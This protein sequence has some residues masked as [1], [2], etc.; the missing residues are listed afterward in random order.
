MTK[1]WYSVQGDGLGH[2]IRSHT[3]IQELKKKHTILIT[4]SDKAYEYLKNKHQ[5]VHK[6]ESLKW[7]YE[8]NTVKITKSVKNFF[9]RIPYVT[10]T[11]IKILKKIIPEFKPEIIITDFEPTASQVAH[12]LKIPIITIDNIHFLSECEIKLPEIKKAELKRTII[13]IRLLFPKSDKYIIPTYYKT[14]SYNKNVK[15]VNPIIRDEIKQTKPKK[16]QHVLVYQTTPTN[17][18]MLKELKKSKNAFKIYGMKKKGKQKNLQFIDFNEKQFINDL[19]KS[20]YVIVNGGFT[21]ISEALYLGKPILAIPIKK[22]IEQEIN[23]YALKKT[24]YGNC[25]KK[26]TFEDL[27]NFEK[28]LDKYY[29]KIEKIKNWNNDKIFQEIEKT[30]EKLKKHPKQNTNNYKI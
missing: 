22:Q 18:D 26:L 13:A 7:I 23:G 3:I 2:A 15:L 28:N 9:K 29:K 21:V 25:T 14:K 19:K 8:N 5:N 11:N 17:K 16:H 12:I 1:I 20:K 24:G 4:A 30:I 6:I 27:E 10:K